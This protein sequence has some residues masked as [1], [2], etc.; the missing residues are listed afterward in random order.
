M[1]IK[2]SVLY[3]HLEHDFITP[4]MSD[5]W[6]SFMDSVSDYICPNFKNRSMGL[7]CDFTDVITKVY[8]AVFPAD[9]VLQ[10]II[11]DNIRNAM[12]FVHHPSIWDI[13]Q[14]P[15]IFYQ[16]DTS[17]L[18][19]LKKREIS[20]YNLHVPL[21]NYS[22]YSTSAS[23]A[24]VLGIKQLKTFAPYFGGYAGVIGKSEI[25]AVAELKKIYEEQVGHIVAFYNYGDDEI[26]NGIVAVI[27]GGGLS[28]GIKEVA[29]NDINLFITGITVKNQFSLQAH[30]IAEENRI[31]ILGATHYSTEKFACMAMLD[32]F[33]KF[34]LPA[35]FIEDVPILEDM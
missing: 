2:A 19:E 29:Q 25:N 15:E 21:D 8:T 6:A 35:E 1:S 33:R 7:V 30:K 34:N 26:R 12:L 16:M 22:E 20:I 23:L 14:A 31:N 17:L 24:K 11:D 28:E 18:D 5:D 9:R 27:A 3:E 10:K 32:Y 13:R 4:A